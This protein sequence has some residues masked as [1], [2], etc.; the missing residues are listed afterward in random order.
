QHDTETAGMAIDG[1]VQAQRAVESTRSVEHTFLSRIVPTLCDTLRDAGYEPSPADRVD[2]LNVAR[3]AIAGA[4]CVKGPNMYS[5]YRSLITNPSPDFETALSLV[6]AAVYLYTSIHA[7]GGEEGKRLGVE[8]F[9]ALR[10]V[11]QA[12]NKAKTCTDSNVSADIWASY[13]SMAAFSEALHTIYLRKSIE[14]KKTV[15]HLLY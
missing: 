13:E 11:S 2:A 9:H 12:R 3:H 14:L 8:W 4:L 10:D 6:S 5:K 7:V 1:L 15:E